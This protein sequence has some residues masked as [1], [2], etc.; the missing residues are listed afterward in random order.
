MKALGGMAYT[1]WFL[2]PSYNSLDLKDAL[3]ESCPLSSLTPPFLVLSH[4]GS[5]TALSGTYVG[6]FLAHH[7]V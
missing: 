3:A 4:S 1:P 5:R 2:L 7:L 6:I